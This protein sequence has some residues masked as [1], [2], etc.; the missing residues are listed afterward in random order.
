MAANELPALALFAAV[1]LAFLWKAPRQTLAAYLPAA[2]LI[3]VPFFATNYIAF[4]TFNIPYAHRTA[5]DEWYNYT[6]ERNGKTY[7][8]YWKNPQGFD[9][10]EKSVAVYALNVLVGHHGIF[11]LTP[12]WLLSVLGIFCRLRKAADR[13]LRELALVI[14]AVSLVCILYFIFQPQENRNYGGMTSGFRWVFWMAPLWIL[15]LLP[16]ADLFSNNK[17][18]KGLALAMLLVSVFSA[19]YPLWNPWVNP[20]IVDVWQYLH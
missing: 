11:S 10:G 3:A 17:W 15:A 19:A 4:G 9:R 5:G 12:I 16:A 7:D 20:W 13:K 2:L 1:S 14:G 18:L 6:Y 8:S